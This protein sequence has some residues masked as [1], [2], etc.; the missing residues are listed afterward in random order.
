MPV[1]IRPNPNTPLRLMVCDGVGY[2]NVTQAIDI[3]LPSDFFSGLTLSPTN[4]SFRTLGPKWGSALAPFPSQQVFVR[5]LVLPHGDYRLTHTP[6]RTEGDMFVPHSNY[7]SSQYAYSFFEM[8]TIPN[9]RAFTN[10]Q[11]NDLVPMMDPLYC[12]NLV[13]GTANVAQ[14]GSLPLPSPDPLYMIPTSPVV[15]ASGVAKYPGVSA[16]TVEQ[17][18]MNPLRRNTFAHGRRDGR[19][20]VPNRGS[21]DPFETGDFDTGVAADP[22]GPYM[23]YPDEGDRRRNVGDP[24]Y[25]N[26]LL[27]APKAAS[28][29]IG[30]PCISPNFLLRSPVDFGSLPSGV[31][32]RVPWQ[33]LRFRPDYGMNDPLKKMR[34]MSDK[35]PAGHTFANFCGPKDH[36]F[37]DMFWMPVVEPWSISEPFS[38]KGTINLN[39]QIFPFTYVER[40]TALHALLRGER[41]MAIP[42]TAAGQYKR[43]DSPTGEPH[44]AADATYRYFVDAKETVRQFTR[45]YKDGKDFDP[46]PPGGN[47]LAFNAFRSASEICE[48]YLVPEDES[49][50]ENKFNLEWTIGTESSS[51]QPVGFWADHRLTGDNV[52]ERPYANLYPRVTVRSNVFKLHMVAQTLQ[53]ATSKDPKTF[54]SVSDVVTAEWRGS[55]MIERSIDPR[56]PLLSNK[57]YTNLTSASINQ[58]ATPK[59]DRY[60]T[61]RVTEVKQLTQ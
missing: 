9:A 55:C 58:V 8:N 21:S 23:N 19:N 37:L 17:S 36:F 52:R 30:G 50:S 47:D 61:Y 51:G 35:P 24:Y 15:T 54:D 56:D 25:R 27:V 1:T 60:Y 26:K 4:E 20:V 31:N 40:T 57:D 53:K 48:M 45:R 10:A 59:L 32:C 43:T 29:G 16:D 38:T 7:R 46:T 33:T 18:S 22:D 28:E 3:V 49:A 44:S 41:M 13:M 42:N 12:N 11:Y 39:Q 2:T 5:S 6:L 14:F 34:T